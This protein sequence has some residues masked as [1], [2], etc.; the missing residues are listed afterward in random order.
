[1]D[2]GATNEKLGSDIADSVTGGGLYSKNLS[3]AD[4]SMNIHLF[5]RSIVP[6]Y[7]WNSVAPSGTRL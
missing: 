3:K 2:T 5:S 6:E 1:M 7:R 4:V